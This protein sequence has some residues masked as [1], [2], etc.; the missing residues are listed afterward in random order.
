MEANLSELEDSNSLIETQ[1]GSAEGV[2]PA[3]PTLPLNA[4]HARWLFALLLF[5]EDYLPPDELSELR[6]IA[7]TCLRIC[8]WQA[9]SGNIDQQGTGS[10]PEQEEMRVA[11]WISIRAVATGWNQHD[12]P[13]DAE[14]MF[15][16]L[17]QSST[18][19]KL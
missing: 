14:M 7:K 9:T 3:S 6:R 11:C 5:L 1:P 16:K 15:A 10:T 13:R 18:T 4:H 12:L 8:K 19:M 17:A 2:F